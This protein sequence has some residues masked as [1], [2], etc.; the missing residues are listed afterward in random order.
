[1]A[2]KS[3]KDGADSGNE[4]KRLDI[5]A[6]LVPLLNGVKRYCPIPSTAKLVLIGPHSFYS[7]A[8]YSDLVIVCKQ[9]KWNVHKI[10][11]GAQS[12]YF[13]K[14][15]GGKFKVSTIKTVLQRPC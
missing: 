4:S 2:E 11:L 8:Q 1:M 15:C 14:Q 5:P 3:K 10:I 13:Q 9:S 7:S 12:E 6:P